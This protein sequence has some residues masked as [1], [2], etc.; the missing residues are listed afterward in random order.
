MIIAIILLLVGVV[1]LTAIL[2]LA[3]GY[4]AKAL[5]VVDR[6]DEERKLHTG[7]VPL[8]GGVPIFLV[9]WGMVYCLYHYFPF[10]GISNLKIGLAG[11][12]FGSAILLFVGIADD[13][14]PFSGPL[15]LLLIVLAIFVTAYLMPLS[16]ITNP[17]GGTISLSGIVG[18]VLVFGWLLIT[19]ISTKVLDGVDGLAGSVVGAGALIISIMTFSKKFFQPNVALVALI[20]LA[21]ILGFLVFNW[22]RAQVFLG[23]SGSLFLGFMLGGLAILAGS[24]MATALLVMAVPVLDVARVV[25]LRWRT[26]QPLFNGDRKHLHFVLLDNGFKEWQV[27]G[28][29]TGIALLAGLIGLWLQSYQKILALFVLAVGFVFFAAGFKLS[30]KNNL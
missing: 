16:K 24:K 2:T 22:P 20:L 10:W 25:Y 1:F 28:I 9:F 27:V 4:I 12:F 3:N 15:R 23:E 14:K 13:V 6:P 11:L 7:E 21:V 18:S 17:L 30:P 26:H 19:T 5:K 29:L 8:W